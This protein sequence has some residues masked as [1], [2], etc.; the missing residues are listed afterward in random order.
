LRGQWASLATLLCLGCSDAL[1][2]V[3][4]VSVA[5]TG[6]VASQPTQVS[7]QVD[8]ALAFQVDYGQSS[9]SADTQMQVLIGPMELGTGTYPPDGLVR[10][11]LP[12]VLP[13]GTYNVTVKMG[14]GR[15]AALPNA[16]TVDGGSWPAAYIIDA[17]GDQRA[18]VAFSVTLRA[19]GPQ[20]SRFEGNVLLGLLGDGTVSPTIS[21][22]F[23]SGVRIENVTI[24]GTG[25]F[26]LL[27][28][29]INGGNGQS[30]PFTVAP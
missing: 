21:G 7:V 17:I 4:I 1:P 15:T 6:M 5:P 2:P 23:S 25:E 20:A 24:S 12:T 9:V 10:G 3:S 16:F 19:V 8:A 26:T 29:D 13:A 11:V 18:N 27:A 14:D 30:T 28:S 22:A